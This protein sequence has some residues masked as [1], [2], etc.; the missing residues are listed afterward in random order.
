[1][2]LSQVAAIRKHE[3]VALFRVCYF[4]YLIPLIMIMINEMTDEK[5]TTNYNGIQVYA[6]SFQQEM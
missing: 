3:K 1:M 2:K 5:R 6:T 4:F